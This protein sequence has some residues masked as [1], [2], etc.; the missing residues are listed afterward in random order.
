MLLNK[1]SILVLHLKCECSHYAKYFRNKV[2][3]EH[4]NVTIGKYECSVAFIF[5]NLQEHFKFDST[6][7]R[8]ITDDQMSSDLAKQ[9]EMDR[10]YENVDVGEY[11]RSVLNEFQKITS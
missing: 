9:Q 7:N 6:N 1:G 11:H 8:L 3:Y 5:R 10:M 4:G 2:K